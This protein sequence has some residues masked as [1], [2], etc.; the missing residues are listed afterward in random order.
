ML[1]HTDRKLAVAKISLVFERSN[2]EG[3]LWPLLL[4]P[5]PGRAPGE[6]IPDGLLGALVSF[7]RPIHPRLIL[8]G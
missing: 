5:H 3:N 6:T 2:A 7:P 1:T 8:Y 4:P